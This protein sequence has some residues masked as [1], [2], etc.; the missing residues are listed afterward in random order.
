M[1][2]LIIVISGLVY[3]APTYN[4][5]AIC[6]NEGWKVAMNGREVWPRNLQMYCSNPE[7]LKNNRGVPV[8]D[9]IDHQTRN[10][11]ISMPQ[12]PDYPKSRKS[13]PDLLKAI[14]GVASA[15]R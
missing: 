9:Y 6:A 14:L 4:S 8:K 12:K 7:D 11:V 5:L 2:T 3:E 1:W 15:L 10:S 13:E